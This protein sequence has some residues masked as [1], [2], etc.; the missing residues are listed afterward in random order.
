[1]ACCCAGKTEPEEEDDE[2]TGPLE[3]RSCTDILFLIFFAAFLIG[4]VV[5][6]GIG[7][8]RG[9]PNRI[10]KG[11]DVAGNICGDNNEE[12]DGVKFSGENLEGNKYLYFDILRTAKMLGDDAL[13]ATLQSALEDLNYDATKMVNRDFCLAEAY[14]VTTTT[15]ASTRTISNGTQSLH[16][17]DKGVI[18]LSDTYFETFEDPTL[19]NADK[20]KGIV[21]SSRLLKND[22]TIMVLLEEDGE[23]RVWRTS[24]ASTADTATE[25]LS[26]DPVSLALEGGGACR[27]CVKECPQDYKQFL[28]RCIPDAV[29]SQAG[30]LF[31][32]TGAE[33]FAE[34]LVGDF[35]NCAQELVYMGLVALGLSLVMTLLFRF[36]AGVI[37]YVIIGVVV[38]ACLAGTITLW[39]IWYLK[40]TDLDKSKT[41][42]ETST[43]L[44]SAQNVTKSLL[45]GTATAKSQDEV[46]QFLVGA[47]IATIILVIVLLVLLVMRKRIKLVVTLFKEA[48]KAVHAMPILVL[49]PFLTFIAMTITTVFWIYGS[50]W[51]FTAGDPEI[52]SK[53][54]YVKYKPDEFLLWMR[55]Y[56]IFGLLWLTQFCIACQHLVIAGSVA[57]WYFSKDKGSVGVGTVLSAFYRLVRYHLGTAAFG[58]FIIA[59]IQL[60]RIILKYLE[61]KVD[62]WEKKGCSGSMMIVLILKGI[63]KCAQCLLWC[64]EKCMKYINVNAYIETAIY[65]YNFCR[66]AMKAFQMLTSNALRVAAIN[67][68]GSFVLFLG[69]IAVV[70]GT[71]FI[72]LKI[73]EAKTGD[74]NPGNYVAHPW[75][76][77]LVS[78][79]F[80][81]LT[82][83]CFISV[84]GMAIDTIFLCFCEDSTRN[85]G[86]NKPYFMSKGLMEFVE[87]SKKALEAAERR[88]MKESESHQVL[89][90]EKRPFSA[91]SSMEMMPS[92][93]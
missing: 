91:S 35:Q 17:D 81:Y 6:F 65:G 37:V 23:M 14:S 93:D 57:G 78:T 82:A 50:L 64:F 32:G 79:C 46:T 74:G 15:S 18:K 1:M 26:Q 75:A 85:D 39:I 8:S 66:A 34:D 5:L 80:S 2:L 54:G 44:S 43:E 42:T 88:K 52:D 16:N 89:V 90:Q 40:M 63:L 58:S 31:S 47:I 11:T 84:Y 69:K 29:T 3:D 76:P 55:W 27:Y 73:M 19:S 10:I 59:L 36:L 70:I 30:G 71:F 22:S 86:I 12:I 87:N 20:V 62:K 21:L 72:S 49:L 4:M 41:E 25:L 92:V 60:I 83:H 13:S 24:M 45:G 28:S 68:V 51:I 61:S 7:V 56:H 38:V 77:I 9:N 48:G 67:S 53:T 33:S